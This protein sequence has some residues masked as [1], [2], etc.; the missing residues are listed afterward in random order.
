MTAPMSWH[1]PN[2]IL[3]SPILRVIQISFAIKRTSDNF[4]YSI[5][6]LTPLVYMYIVYFTVLK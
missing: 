2:M 6:S 1:T 4:F 3:A 5:H